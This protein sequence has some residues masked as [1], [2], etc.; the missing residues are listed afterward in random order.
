MPLEPA[1]STT[2]LRLRVWLGG[3][4]AMAFTGVGATWPQQE[5]RYLATTQ[6]LM[7]RRTSAWR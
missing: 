3:L 1:G 7:V 4:F 6:T 5:G 2:A